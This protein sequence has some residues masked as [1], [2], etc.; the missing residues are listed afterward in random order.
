[1][2][3]CLGFYNFTDRAHDQNKHY[4]ILLEFARMNLHQ[5]FMEMDPPQLAGEI[6]SQWKSFCHIAQAIE[7]LHGFEYDG[8]QW[9]G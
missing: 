2:L 5:F 6:L 8:A 1:M 3:R 7:T 9:L 4:N